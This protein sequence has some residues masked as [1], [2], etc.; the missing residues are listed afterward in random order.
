MQRLYRW[1]VHPAWIVFLPGVVSG[2][3]LAASRLTRVGE[4]I[5]SPSPVYF[6]L[7]RAAQTAPRAWS[8]VPMVLDRG[9]WVWDEDRLAAAVVLVVNLDRGVV[10][11]SNSDVR[12]LMLLCRRVL[13]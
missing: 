3:Y 4:H 13:R 5:L 6:H 12:H 1:A 9:R 11:S 7:F 2:L 10:L 8:D